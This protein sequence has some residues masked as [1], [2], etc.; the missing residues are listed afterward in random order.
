MAK[1]FSAKIAPVV[2]LIGIWWDSGNRIVVFTEMPDRSKAVHGICDSDFAHDDCWLD[3]AKQLS[4]ST[5]T[6]YFHVP[7]GRVMWHVKNATS[8]IL[9][10]NETGRERL[11]LIASEFRLSNWRAEMDDHYMIGDPTDLFWD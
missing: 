5:D 8:V 6:E 4:I 2:P 9:H 1:P 3:A 10:G 11:E 7:R